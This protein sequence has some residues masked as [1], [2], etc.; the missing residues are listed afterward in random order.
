MLRISHFGFAFGIRQ[1]NFDVQDPTKCK[2]PICDTAQWTPLRLGPP[3]LFRRSFHKLVNIEYLVRE[4]KLAVNYQ[5]LGRQVCD[6]LGEL[7][8]L[9]GWLIW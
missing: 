7:Q 3:T 6:C 9:A 8:D 5:L 1:T 2:S 4:G